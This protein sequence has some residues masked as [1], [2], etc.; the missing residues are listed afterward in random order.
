MINKRGRDNSLP[1]SFSPKN[2]RALTITP[3]NPLLLL[4]VLFGAT[5][6]RINS[7]IFL[8]IRIVL[9]QLRQ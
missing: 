9:L 7:Q 5:L 4:L 2:R 3:N 1:L 8:H 6:A